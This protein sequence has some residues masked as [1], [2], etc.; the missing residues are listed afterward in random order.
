M[1]IFLVLESRARKPIPSG[2]ASAANMPGAGAPPGR[3]YFASASRSDSQHKSDSSPTSHLE[4]TDMSVAEALHDLT[5]YEVATLQR[6]AVYGDDNA[7][8]EL[9][10]AYETGYY[11]HRNCTKA[12][13]WVRIAAQEGSPEAEYNLGLRY[14]NGDGIAIDDSEAERW[15]KEAADH[16]YF[17]AKLP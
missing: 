17:R 9:G 11:V 2:A 16:G 13:Y 1:A 15:L 4:I 6:A 10:M 8:F 14:R 12:A 3:V 5:R 7:A